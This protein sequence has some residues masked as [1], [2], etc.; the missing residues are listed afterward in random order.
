MALSKACLLECHGEKVVVVLQ[1]QLYFHVSSTRS[2]K[3]TWHIA[4][5]SFNI[6]KP[7]HFIRIWSASLTKNFI[8]KLV[9]IKLLF[10]FRKH[11]FLNSVFEE[12]TLYSNAAEKKFTSIFEVG[13]RSMKRLWTTLKHSHLCESRDF[14]D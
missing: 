14:K 4:I 10:S 11:L 9:N 13:E 5:S 1:R 12:R 3:T 2:I 6:Q 8:Y 7:R